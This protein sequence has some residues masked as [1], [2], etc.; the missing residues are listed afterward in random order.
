MEHTHFVSGGRLIHDHAPDPTFYPSG[1]SMADRAIG[2]NRR[3][4]QLLKDMTPEQ[5]IAYDKAI[6]ADRAK[7]KKESYHG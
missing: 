1:P 5:F 2:I 6:S 4:K 7:A 3:L